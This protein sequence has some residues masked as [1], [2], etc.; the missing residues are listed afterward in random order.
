ML[1]ALLFA[2][3]KRDEEGVW[4]RYR[5]ALSTYVIWQAVAPQDVRAFNSRVQVGAGNY[6]PFFKMIGHKVVNRIGNSLLHSALSGGH[7]E[8]AVWLAARGASPDCQNAS[9][10]TAV[11]GFVFLVT[12]LQC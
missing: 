7:V 11:S 8:V 10:S 4:A 5:L 6:G 12:P 2:K 3:L 1:E 9:G